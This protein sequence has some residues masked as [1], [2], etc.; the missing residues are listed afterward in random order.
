MAVAA[1]DIYGSSDTNR[2]PQH[3]TSADVVNTLYRTMNVTAA[4]VGTNTLD[5]GY[6]P[7]GAIPVGGYWGGEDLDTGTEALD[8]DLG[9]AANGVDSADPDYF[10][11]AG[12]WNG[13][14]AITDFAFTNSVNVR[15][16]TGP[17]P[18]TQL[19]AKT[20][21]QIVCNTAAN[22]GGTGKI[23]VKIDYLT[24]GISTV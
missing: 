23:V 6:L 10:S 13:D 4:F 3:M 21:V 2:A 22:A 19:G 11:N 14:N 12:I 16:I 18:V 8:L 5:V 7:K 17:F 20:L 1:T 9:I 24:P 15:M